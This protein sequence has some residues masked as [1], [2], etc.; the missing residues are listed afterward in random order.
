MTEFYFKSN[1]KFNVKVENGYLSWT[2][3]GFMNYVNRG[4]KGEKSIPIK[5][6]TAIQIKDPRLTTGYIQFAYSGATES[7]GGVFDAVKDENTIT[8]N[9]KNDL[10]Q[11]KELKSIV[12]SLRNEEKQP[13]ITQAT[14]A[15][16]IIKYKHLLDEGILTQEEFEAKKKQI[17]GM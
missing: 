17:L 14:D 8:F 5:S 10:A 11:A 15:D 9:S 16:E 7:K 13:P 4:S 2:S 3:K 6:I 12:E 1:G